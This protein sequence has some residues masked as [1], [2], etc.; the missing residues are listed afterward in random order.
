[1]TM[2][3]AA[4]RALT[5]PG[6]VMNSERG[7]QTDFLPSLTSTH[8]TPLCDRAPETVG[9]FLWRLID[10]VMLIPFDEQLTSEKVGRANER[11]GW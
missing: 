4:S 2:F 9:D 11:L 8:C 7:I 5:L 3:P 10:V 1:M 6:L